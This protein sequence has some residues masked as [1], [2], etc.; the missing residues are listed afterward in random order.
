MLKRA[1]RSLRNKPKTLRNNIAMGV[2]GL[3]TFGVFV[4]WQLFAGML[5]DAT[6]DGVLVQTEDAAGFSN[7]FDRLGDQAASVKKAFSEAV[8]EADDETVVESVSEV[9]GPSLDPVPRLE[10]AARE[11]MNVSSAASTR[12]T[13]G[14]QE[15]SVLAP[16][17]VRIVTVKGL[18]N[19]QLEFS[20][21][22]KD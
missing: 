20:Y 22:E 8:E 3:F 4:V 11:R 2:A 10:Q 16:K 5:Q 9:D 13:G 1:I 7:F 15:S 18:F 17:P 6:P 19:N 21:A 12:D 14:V